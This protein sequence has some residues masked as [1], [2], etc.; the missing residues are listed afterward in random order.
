MRDNPT[1]SLGS[2]LHQTGD[3]WNKE[4]LSGDCRT[5]SLLHR[6]FWFYYKPK[7]WLKNKRDKTRD[8]FQGYGYYSEGFGT[9]TYKRKHFWNMPKNAEP[10]D[11][12]QEAGFTCKWDSTVKN[13]VKQKPIDTTS[14]I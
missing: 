14:P 13:W 10:L 3:Y 6:Y 7:W 4:I 1:W 8:W 5:R 12:N 2:I 11:L 9:W